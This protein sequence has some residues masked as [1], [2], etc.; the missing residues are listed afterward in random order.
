MKLLGIPAI[1]LFRMGA[2][3]GQPGLVSFMLRV[4]QVW[5]LGQQRWQE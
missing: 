5:P 2:G 4:P 3:L 1:M